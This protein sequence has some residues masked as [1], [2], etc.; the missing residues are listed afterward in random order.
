MKSKDIILS[1]NVYTYEIYANI[2]IKTNYYFEKIDITEEVMRVVFEKMMIES[3]KN[4]NKIIEYY[5]KDIGT[6]KYI[7]EDKG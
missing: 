6:L 5:I 2:N 1:L 3:I 4:D 7:P